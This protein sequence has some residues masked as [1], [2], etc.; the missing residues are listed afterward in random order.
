MLSFDPQHSSLFSC[1]NYVSPTIRTMPNSSSSFSSFPEFCT[2][3]CQWLW[4]SKIY[5]FSY[6]IHKE[7]ISRSFL[8]GGRVRAPSKIPKINDSELD[9]RTIDS[10]EMLLETAL[11][12]AAFIIDR[13]RI[14]FETKKEAGKQSPPLLCAVIITRCHYHWPPLNNHHHPRR[15]RSPPPHLWFAF[16]TSPID[17]QNH[18]RIPLCS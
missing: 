6:K 8:P 3:F 13:R 12:F 11:S 7:S 2:Y 1:V 10:R 15:I 16:S 4:F 5:I 17:L 9:E 18:H 14:D